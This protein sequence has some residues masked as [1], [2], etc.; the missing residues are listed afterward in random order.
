MI[1][2]SSAGPPSRWAT[3]PSSRSRTW[4]SATSCSP[5]TAA[6]TSARPGCSVCTDPRR[7]RL[8][9][10]TLASGRK[11][12]STPDHV[13]FAGFVIGRTPQQHMTYVMWKAGVGFRVGTSRTYTN[14]QVKAVLG[15]AQRCTQEHARRALG[16]LGARDRGRGAV[17]RGVPG[18]ART[19]S[20][21][22]RS[23]R[24]PQ[25]H[26]ATDGWSATRTSS[27]GCSSSSTPTRAASDFSP[28][29]A[30]RSTTR[31]TS[32]RHA[33]ESAS[34]SP[35]RRL[36]V[37]LCGDRRGREPAAPHLAVRLRRR[38][39]AGA[40]VDRAE[41]ASGPQGFDRLAL[42]DGTRRNGQVIAETVEPDPQRP[43]RHGPSG[44]APR[45]Q[46]RR[47]RHELAAVH[48]R[49]VGAA[50]HGHGRRRRRVR[51]RD[52]RSR[53]PISTRA[54][55]CSTSTSS[56]PTTSSPTGSSPTTRST[57]SAGPTTGT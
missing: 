51:R 50:G 57:A 53:R 55:P 36:S 18:G 52:D 44:G 10:I 1:S 23:S 39:P 49:V 34:G 21:P 7:T 37:V 31:T 17:P 24:A 15:P 3:A 41:R 2:A 11:L 22:C 46:P 29:T 48:A 25:G 33:T 8:V 12:V 28:T 16:R 35:R 32:R 13:H 27:T 19:D 5:P 26:R 45:R 20:R 38:G 54:F 43:R 4:A 30:C 47:R 6:A 9:D 56:A 42:R 14:G 40:R